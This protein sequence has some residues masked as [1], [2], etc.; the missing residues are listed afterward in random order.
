[1]GAFRFS[2]LFTIWGIFPDFFPGKNISYEAHF[3]GLIIGVIF[4]IYYKKEGPQPQK[5]S[6]EN[7]TDEIQENEDGIHGDAY[8]DAPNNFDDF[9]FK[10]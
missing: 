10:L 7:E 5:Y 3:W 6:W 9:L 8:W 2:S 4:A 1:M